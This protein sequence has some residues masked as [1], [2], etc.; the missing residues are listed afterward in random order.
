L[1][2]LLEVKNEVFSPLRSFFL[3]IFLLVLAYDSIYP[4]LARGLLFFPPHRKAGSLVGAYVGAALVL[5][6]PFTIFN[7]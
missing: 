4:I 3:G 7:F 6:L 2:K 1:K 5:F